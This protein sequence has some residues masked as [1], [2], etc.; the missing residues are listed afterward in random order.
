MSQHA[1]ALPRGYEIEG[2]RIEGTLGTGGFGITYLAREV[3][4][5]RRVAIKEY[6][7][8]QVATRDSKRHSV[9]PVGPD[10]T[11]IFEWGLERFRGEALT[12]VSFRHANIVAVLRF[13][14]A[15]NTAYMVMDYEEGSSLGEILDDAGTLPEHEI[16]EILEPL[17]D[18]LDRVHRVG[19][20]HRDIK[21]E[22]IYVR[23]DGSPVL[24][25]F[26]AARLATGQH[27]KHLTG[28]VTVGYAPPEQYDSGTPQGPWTDIYSF[29]ATLYHAATGVV[30][31]ESTARVGALARRQPDPLTPIGKAARR[32]GY[33]EPVLHAIEWALEVIADDRPQSVDEWREAFRPVGP[34]PRKRRHKRAEPGP[35]G[36]AAGRG[37]QAQRAGA[38]RG[39]AADEPVRD[40]TILAGA[41]PELAHEP[42]REA[43][44]DRRAGKARVEAKRAEAIHAE[45]MRAE[46]PLA[47]QRAA[48]PIHRSRAGRLA[49]AGATLAAVA[50]VAFGVHLVLGEDSVVQCDRAAAHP[51]DPNKP[52]SI[53]GVSFREMDGNKAIAAC[54]EAAKRN[55]KL[56]RPRF[57]QA[58]ALHKLKRYA[59]ART[60]YRALAA[61]GYVF[62]EVNLAYMIFRGQG[63]PSDMEEGARRFRVSAIK[64]NP[65]AQL[66]LAGAY[67]WG[68]GVERDDEA[69]YFWYRLA[70]R[71]YP[72][73][74][75]AHLETLR[76]R[77]GADLVSE[78]ERRIGEW[79]PTT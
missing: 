41:A 38:A 75:K 68:N 57:N 11:E 67:M 26:G 35:W 72:K 3:S 62:A 29:G 73:A 61:R 42:A 32:G 30:P 44:N 76:R 79:K 45:P 74:T 58:R 70:S 59:E 13:F 66:A 22:N 4:L 1:H 2:Y 9:R 77:L 8:A 69:A 20:L 7:P 25:D 34:A 55:P 71:F 19:F 78:I 63:A 10:D 28:L 23:A 60:I 56:D 12:L 50:V 40:P 27:G 51:F 31:V 21:P 16:E 33:S 65:D 6:L 5:D 24:L 39:R 47:A 18:G 17:L 53:P 15:N 54:A 49:R 14:E 52:R 36:T 37:K 43:T 46:V 64:G 48:A